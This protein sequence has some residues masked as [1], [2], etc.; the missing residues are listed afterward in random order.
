MALGKYLDLERLLSTF[1]TEL[2]ILPFKLTT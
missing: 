1:L 2:V